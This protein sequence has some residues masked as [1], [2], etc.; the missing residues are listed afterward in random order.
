MG[1]ASFEERKAA[2][3][4]WLVSEEPNTSLIK[5]QEKSCSESPWEEVMLFSQWPSGSAQTSP[6]P[7]GWS[8]GGVGSAV[9]QVALVHGLGLWRW[10]SSQQRLLKTLDRKSGR[11][12]LSHVVGHRSP[13][14][15][16]IMSF[17][18][19]RSIEYQCFW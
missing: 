1:K 2:L 9:P 6:R 7:A 16:Q 10:L 13:Y 12:N 19:L 3:S 11:S 5:W 4:E 18:R 8:Q 17:S 15:Y 14:S